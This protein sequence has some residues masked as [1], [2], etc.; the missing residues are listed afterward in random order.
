MALTN[1]TPPT[2]CNWRI[3]LAALQ[4]DEHRV[5]GNVHAGQITHEAVGQAL[6]REWLSA[7]NALS[8]MMMS[9]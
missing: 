3:G 2:P 7:E 8:P 4:D 1:A 9:A 5:M 6:K